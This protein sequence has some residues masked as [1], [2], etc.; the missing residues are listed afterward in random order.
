MK[1]ALSLIFSLSVTPIANAES[2]SN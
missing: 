1:I 2:N